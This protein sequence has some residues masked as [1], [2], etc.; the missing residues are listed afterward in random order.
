MHA[1]SKYIGHE[2]LRSSFQSGSSRWRTLATSISTP[3]ARPPT[4]NKPKR[5]YKKIKYGITGMFLHIYKDS[6]CA[7]SLRMLYQNMPMFD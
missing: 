5:H 2:T 6:S 4:A 1:K 7:G 3:V